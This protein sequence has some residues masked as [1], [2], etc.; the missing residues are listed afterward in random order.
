MAKL[1]DINLAAVDKT[2][3]QKQLD[4]LIKQLNEWARTISNEGTTNVLRDNTGTNR[5]LIG[6]FP[7]KSD[8]GIVISKT[9]ISVLDVFN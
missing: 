6:L 7:D 8:A 3:L 5:I 4:S 2:D 9:G 1:D